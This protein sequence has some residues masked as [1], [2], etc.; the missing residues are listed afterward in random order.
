MEK[1]QDGK[2]NTVLGPAEKITEK[3]GRPAK[4]WSF[5]KMRHVG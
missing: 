1:E 2:S 5:Q 4:S 3:A